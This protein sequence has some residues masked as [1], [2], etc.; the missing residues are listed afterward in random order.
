MIKY[1]REKIVIAI[2]IALG[3]STFLTTQV[4]LGM[5]S[6]VPTE[7]EWNV[8][9]DGKWSDSDTWKHAENHHTSYLIGNTSI[10]PRDYAHFYIHNDADYLYILVDMCPD[11]TED[12]DEDWLSIFLWTRSLDEIGNKGYNINETHIHK[13]FEFFTYN[14]S[15]YDDGYYCPH[16]SNA[17]FFT[18][19][20]GPNWWD[21]RHTEFNDT[22][23]EKKVLEPENVDSWGIYIQGGFEKTINS[24]IN[25]TIYEMALKISHLKFQDGSKVKGLDDRFYVGFSGYGT[26]CPSGYEYWWAPTNMYNDQPYESYE[27][28][29]V[30]SNETS[31][32]D[33]NYGDGKTTPIYPP[34]PEEGVI[35]L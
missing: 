13:G 23:P 10:H 33:S 16:F 4:M 32:F 28:N 24:G 27:C 26:F 7:P 3:M 34:S 31:D 5:G 12:L 22:F 15:V 25:H 20:T 21:Y 35:I 8:T 19:D 30:G 1:N 9:I 6:P 18:V 14:K 17:D 2:A 11:T 29:R